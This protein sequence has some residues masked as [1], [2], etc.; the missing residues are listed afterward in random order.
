VAAFLSLLSRSNTTSLFVQRIEQIP[1]ATPLSSI[2]YASMFDGILFLGT[3]EIESTVRKVLSVLKMRGGD[4]STDLREIAC[5]KDG[6]Y[7]LDK[8]VGLSGILAGNPQG[9][10]KKTVEEIFQPLYFVRDFIDVLATSELSGEQ[11]ATIIQNLRTEVN[12]LV[13]KLREYFSEEE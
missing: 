9:Q 4:F 13:E 2:T 6:L 7:V 8:F 1:G 12:K 10:Y 3:I 5:G 11:K